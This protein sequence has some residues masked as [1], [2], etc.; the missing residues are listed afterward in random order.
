[1]FETKHVETAKLDD[2]LEHFSF[3]DREDLE[4]HMFDIKTTNMH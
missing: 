4:E 1:M 3:P 2:I